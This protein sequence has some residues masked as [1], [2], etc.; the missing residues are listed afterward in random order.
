M[1]FLNPL[2]HLVKTKP[3]QSV[4]T[5]RLELPCPGCCELS[6]SAEP[7]YNQYLWKH[8]QRD[9]ALSLL[10][11]LFV[12]IHLDRFS[13]LELDDDL[14]AL[15]PNTSDPS[16]KSYILPGEGLL[17][18]LTELLNVYDEYWEYDRFVNLSAFTQPPALNF[19]PDTDVRTLPGFAVKIQPQGDD[20][21]LEIDFNPSVLS[22]TMIYE[23]I[24]LIA[25]GYC[26][27][28]ETVQ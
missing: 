10:S 13:P 19:P 25:A 18:I 17:R 9:A 28:L 26:L 20:L 21:G 12:M 4:E 27:N 2:A 23:Q 14:A 1:T 15:F 8:F 3:L 22:E 7:H 16:G 6:I 11:G 24:S 5:V